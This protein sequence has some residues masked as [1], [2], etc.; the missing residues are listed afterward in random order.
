MS[1]LLT[2]ARGT[3][4]GASRLPFGRLTCSVLRAVGLMPIDLES[5]FLGALTVFMLP[6]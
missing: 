6:V 3:S 1:L 2:G 5:Y 4:R